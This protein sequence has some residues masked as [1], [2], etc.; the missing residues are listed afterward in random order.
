L[1]RQVKKVKGVRPLL[2]VPNGILFSRGYKLYVSDYLCNKFELVGQVHES[3]F[4]R[5]ASSLRVLSRL[6]RA[7]IT[8]G[9]SISDTQHLIAG[10]HRL[11]TIDLSNRNIELD[12]EIQRGSRPLSITKISGVA[13][14][15]DAICYGEYWNNA[16]KDPVSIW[17]RNSDGHWR[18][19]FT[20]A[21][22]TIEHVHSVIPDSSRGIVWILTGD[23]G[24]AAGFWI[25]KDNFSVVTPVLLGAQEYRCVWLHFFGKEIYYATDSQLTPNSLRRMTFSEEGVVSE[26]VQRIS[27]SSIHSCV[28]ED[29]LAFSTT[30]E[31]G[32]PSGN[33]LFDLFE[34]KLGPGIE[35]NKADLI[36]GSPARGFR[37]VGSWKKDILPPRLLQFGTISFPSGHN[38]TNYLYAYFTGLSGVDDHTVVFDL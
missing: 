33:L 20:F 13:G 28:V 9:C 22:G 24:N 6:F 19:A 14:F 30:V 5:I 26:V 31:P 16:N 34:Y 15:D 37:L 29:S 11:W 8:L 35:R 3:A 38:P 10:K 36:L 23:F 1:I 18:I 25:A 12:H 17:T 4:R 21:R 32:I 27:G 2:F 7:G